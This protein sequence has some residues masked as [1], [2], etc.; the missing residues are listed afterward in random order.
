[1]LHFIS[2]QLKKKVTQGGS[3]DFEVPEENEINMHKNEYTH[4]YLLDGT[5]ITSL[6]DVP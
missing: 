6:K 2:K 5:E 3:L 4:L 1:M